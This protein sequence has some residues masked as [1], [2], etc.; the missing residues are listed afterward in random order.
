MRCLASLIFPLRAHRTE[1]RRWENLGVEVPPLLLL[2]IVR[3]TETS[4]TC[5][6]R[7]YHGEAEIATTPFAISRG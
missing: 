5:A 4:G 7:P 2:G 1:S 3:L 6:A